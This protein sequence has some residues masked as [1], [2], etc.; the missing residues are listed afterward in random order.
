MREYRTGTTPIIRSLLL[1]VLLLLIA[2]SA[3][4]Y[5]I[6]FL[7][8]GRLFGLVNLFD[9]NREHNLPTYFSALLVLLNALLFYL[10]YRN[11]PLS[12]YGMAFLLLCG[13]F[14]FLAFDEVFSLHEILNEPLRAYL[15]AE[16]VFYY[17]WLIPYALVA[18]LLALSLIP[19]FLKLPRRYRYLYLLSGAL[20]ISGA[21]LMEMVGGRHFEL[22]GKDFTYHLFTTFE[23]LLEM[24]GMLLCLYTNLNYLEQTTGGVQVT[25]GTEHPAE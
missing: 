10:L 22:H 19:F 21:V 16:G 23:E 7:G 4:I 14:L 24:A 5:S 3:V 25:F 1:V 17:A 6:H 2:N 15:Q 11:K 8:H 13:V 9:F 20:F 18:L 12:R